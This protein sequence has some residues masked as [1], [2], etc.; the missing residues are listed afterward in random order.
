MKYYLD[1]NIV[2]YFMENAAPW[3]TIAETRIM[4]LLAQGIM[5]V[6]S[7][8]TRMECKVLPLR[9][10]DQRL[11][12]QYDRFFSTQAHALSVSTAVCDRAALIRA[13]HGFK[14]LDSLHLAAAVEGGCDAF[15]TNDQ[16]LA[17]FPTVAIEVLV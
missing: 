12:A 5:L 15:L 16:R 13:A 17:K 8:L 3:G 6:V 4:D 2:I 9:R 14:P 1:S 11:L 7:D 10:S